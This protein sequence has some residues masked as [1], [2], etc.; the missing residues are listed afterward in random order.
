M[1]YILVIVNHFTKFAQAYAIPNKFGKMAARKIFDDFVLRFSFPAKIHHDQGREFENEL[2]KK[3]QSYSGIQHSR[4]TPYHSQSNPAERFNRTLLSI[5]QTLEETQKSNWKDYLNKVVHAYNFTVHESTGFSPFFLLYG[6][7]P[8]LL[9][10]LMFPREQV[11][12]QS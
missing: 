2:F 8:T 1:E 12:P 11:S 7:E 6:R 4:T 9:I 3:F 5:L 10:D